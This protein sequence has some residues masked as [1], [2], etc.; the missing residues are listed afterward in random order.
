LADKLTLRRAALL[1]LGSATL[2]L[3]V[4]LLLNAHLG[5]DGYSTLL[6][7]TSVFFEVRFV[8]VAVSVAAVFVSIGWARGIRPGWG[9]L[10][11]PV[12][13]GTVVTLTLP[14]VPEPDQWPL[15]AGQFGL[16]FLILCLGV[17]AYL[18]SD[19]GIGPGEVLARAWDPPFPF[20]WSYSVV[21]AACALVGWWLG[22]DLGVG[23]VLAA[24]VIGPVV[25]RFARL[26]PA[27]DP[28]EREREGQPGM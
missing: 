16:G 12:V 20:K 2:G 7:G 9:T 8:V 6:Q 28:G 26:F 3:G 19:Y 14:L 18:A 24:V 25:N 27:P 21:Q 13:V 4:T 23:T 22:A 15:R 11:Q 5:S 1:V 10:V 17:A